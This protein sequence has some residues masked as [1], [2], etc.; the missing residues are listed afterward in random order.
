MDNDV[1]TRITTEVWNVDPNLEV[2][3]V[4]KWVSKTAIL[5]SI[6]E[7]KAAPVS[8]SN[9]TY[10]PSGVFDVPQQKFPSDVSASETPTSGTFRFV[11]SLPASRNG[12]DGA[13]T[14]K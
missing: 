3:H 9:S 1:F 2:P 12:G 10:S 6:E 7:S 14:T 5:K 13:L 8:T 4:E 11:I